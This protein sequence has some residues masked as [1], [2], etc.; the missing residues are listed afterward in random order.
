MKRAVWTAPDQLSIVVVLT[1]IFPE[2]HWADLV[3]ASLRECSETAAGAPKG[4]SFRKGFN[5][6]AKFHSRNVTMDAN[7]NST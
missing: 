6:I 4:P 3:A 7:F 2:T 5:D 1:V